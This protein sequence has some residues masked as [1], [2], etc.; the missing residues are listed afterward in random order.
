MNEREMLAAK[1]VY[2]MQTKRTP[3]E[4]PARLARPQ[5]QARKRGPQGRNRAQSEGVFVTEITQ[6]RA[7]T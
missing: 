7:S 6:A 1:R 2:N 3:S 4:G 5:G